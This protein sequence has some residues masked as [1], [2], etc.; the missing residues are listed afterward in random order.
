MKPTRLSTLTVN[1]ET[2]QVF[3]WD[4]TQSGL[5]ENFPN[6][7]NSICMGQTIFGLTARQATVPVVISDINF[8]DN[9]DQYLEQVTAISSIG[10]QPQADA[11]F[12]SVNGC[13]TDV[14][15]KGIFIRAGKKMVFH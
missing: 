10:T 4:M 12:F 3:V 6:E 9:V 8:V 2:Q 7:R 1:G 15:A 13:K 5:Y 11:A 14:P